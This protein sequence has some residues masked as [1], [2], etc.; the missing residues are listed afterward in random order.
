VL[1][2]HAGTATAADGSLVTAGGRVL[3]ITAVSDT[4]SDAQRASAESAEAVRLAG[5]HFRRDIGWRELARRRGLGT[6]EDWG[7][8]VQP[9]PH[10]ARGAPPE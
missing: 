7:L 1:V 4:L 10:E 9:A 2:F 6:R 3:A 8:A 5:K